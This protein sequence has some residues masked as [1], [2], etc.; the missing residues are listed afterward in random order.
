MS[1]GKD[2]KIAIMLKSGSN[3]T[4]VVWTTGGTGVGQLGCLDFNSCHVVGNSTGLQNAA[5]FPPHTRPA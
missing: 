4:G 5:G 2:R 3:E 1:L